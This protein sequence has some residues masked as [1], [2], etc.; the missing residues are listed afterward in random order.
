[1]VVKKEGGLKRCHRRVLIRVDIQKLFGKIPMRTNITMNAGIGVL[2]LCVFVLLASSESG[3]GEFDW[4]N[5]EKTIEKKLPF[6]LS[7]SVKR[8]EYD[9]IVEHFRQEG[10]SL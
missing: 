6:K 4:S 3:E 8:G 10:V 9:F 7:Y 2:L 5:Y 1:M